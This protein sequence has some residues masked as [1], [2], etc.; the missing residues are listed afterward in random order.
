[1]LEDID[2]MYVDSEDYLD[3]LAFRQLFVNIIIGGE[4]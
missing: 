2:I 3:W 1:M 4:D